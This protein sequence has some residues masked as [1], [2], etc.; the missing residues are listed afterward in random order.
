MAL[1][2][3][4][5]TTSTTLA[6]DRPA[7]SATHRATVGV[8]GAGQLARM[9]I[10]AAG[11]L[12]VRL[13]VLAE[14]ADDCAAEI[15][16]NV[17]LGSP[18]SLA[19]LSAFAAAN[20][21]TTFDHELVDA[22][23]LEVLEAEGHRLR[24]SAAV[25]GLVQDKLA[26]RRV[27]RD[28]GFPVPAFAAVNDRSGL[29]A[30]GRRFGWPIVVKTIQGGYDGR[31]VWVLSDPDAVVRF[32][33]STSVTS[34]PVMVESFV[35]IV[36]ELAILVARRP[37]GDSAVYP[38]VETVQVD[39][40]CR[41]IVAPAPITPTLAAAARDLAI[42]IAETVDATGILAIELF[43]TDR[44]LV[45]NELA[46]RPHNSGHPTIEGCV[47]SQ[48]EQHLRAILDWPLGAT[49]LVRPAVA[50]VNVLGA[51]TVTDPLDRLPLALED[52]RVHVHLYG[53]RA[54]PGRKLGHVTVLADTVEAA[55]EAARN[56]A[57][58][59]TGDAVEGWPR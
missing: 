38:V 39:G 47:T 42:Q 24:P 4:S 51:D 30:F 26:Q 13:R 41:E 43:A 20:D 11:P 34:R 45:V 55:R 21:V 22:A 32:A 50:T 40:I 56:A 31:G 52:P 18:N 9:L 46:A 58:I 27:L 12:A 54:R 19:D 2:S 15:A 29:D 14:R 33:A 10:E 16:S 59:L 5:R 3:D 36:R 37:S 1:A 28:A 57:A 8:V 6:G 48:F 25:V 35:P 17:R 44:G 23:A 53:K 7:A 49:D